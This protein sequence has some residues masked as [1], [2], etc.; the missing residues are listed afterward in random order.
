MKFTLK[1]R[2]LTIWKFKIFQYKKYLIV[3]PKKRSDASN[4]L[5]H[6]FV[7]KGKK[8]GMRGYIKSVVESNFNQLNQQ[9]IRNFN[10]QFKGFFLVF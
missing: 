2:N 3:D 5:K 7:K 4:L 6:P 9:R 1:S 10:K 8:L